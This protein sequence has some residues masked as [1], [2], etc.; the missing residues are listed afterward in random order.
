MRI[1][2][3]GPHCSY[4][5]KNKAKEPKHKP[6]HGL[7]LSP[8]IAARAVPAPLPPQTWPPPLWSSVEPDPQ[9]WSSVVARSVPCRRWWPDLC[10]HRRWWPDAMG[11]WEVRCALPPPPH[12]LIAGRL[13]ARGEGGA[14]PGE[15]GSPEGAW[16]CH[17]RW[18][19]CS[20][21]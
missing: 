7:A 11:E 17:S 19:P 10:P 3:G 1:N 20:R 4:A 2:T 12:T 9:S 5:L 14:P 18:S 6:M 16:R 13:D 15:R 21:Q 8:Y